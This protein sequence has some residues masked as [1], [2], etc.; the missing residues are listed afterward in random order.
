M[1]CYIKSLWTDRV[2]VQEVK[3]GS[4]A[5][6]V[7]KNRPIANTTTQHHNRKPKA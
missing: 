2:N 7:C 5:T 3:R 6:R 4:F 1:R